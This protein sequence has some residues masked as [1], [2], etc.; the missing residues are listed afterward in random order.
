MELC[1]GSVSDALG[2]D[3]AVAIPGLSRSGKHV[4]DSGFEHR[5]AWVAAQQVRERNRI[6]FCDAISYYQ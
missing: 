4:L 3:I 6:L 5:R 1:K 2:H